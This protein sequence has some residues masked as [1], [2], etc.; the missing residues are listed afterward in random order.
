MRDRVK[1]ENKKALPGFLMLLLVSGVF[2]GLVGFGG[3]LAA[4]LGVGERAAA[5]MDGVLRALAVWG[6]PVCSVV[7]LGGGWWLYAAA[8]RRWRGWDGEDEDVISRVEEQLSWA[9]LLSALTVLVDFGCISVGAVYTEGMEG[10]ICVAEM[11]V[12]CAVLVILQQKVVDLERRINPEK[13]GSVYDVHFQKKW[14]ASCDEAEQRQM[15]QAAHKAFVAA[16]YVCFGLWLALFFLD[17]V[18][19]TGLLPMVLVLVILGVMQVTY[20][21]ECIRLSRKGESC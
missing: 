21:L 7:L 1:Q 4:N 15:G 13:R 14:M 8:K 12:S 2:G 16:T 5:A 10:L 6:I 19:D 9:L 11:V 18:F 3:S 17:R 20:T